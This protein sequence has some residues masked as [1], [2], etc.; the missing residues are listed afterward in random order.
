MRDLGIKKILILVA[1][2][3]TTVIA[4]AAAIRGVVTDKTNQEPLIGAT[5]QVHGTTTGTITDF[6]GQFELAGLRNGT[7]TLIVQYVSY[8]TKAVEISVN[9]IADINIELDPDN[10]TLGEVVVTGTARRNT[11]NAILNQ[12]RTSLVMQTGVSSQQIARTQDKDASEVIRRVPGISIIDEKFVM[13]RGLSQRYN[14]VWINNS[15]VPSSEPDSRAFSFDIIPSSQLDNMVVVKSP[16]PQYPSD[17]SGGFVL[18]NT[19]DVPSNNLFTISLGSNLND[20]THFKDFQYNK[21]S[22]TDFLGFDNGYRSLN[23]GIHTNLTNIPGVDRSVDLL[24]NGF[25]NDWKVRNFKPVADMSLSMNVAQRWVTES[26]RTF[27]LLGSANYS[28]SYK[29]LLN[30]ENALFGAYDDANERSVYLH[31]YKDNQY[32]QNVRIGAMLNLTYVPTSGNSRYEFKNIFNQLARDRYTFRQGTDDQD[33]RTESAEYYYNSRTTYNGQFTGKHTLTDESKVDWSGGYAYASQNMPDRRR[34]LVNNSSET[35][36]MWLE[37]P[38]AINREFTK[39]DEHILSANANYEHNF[40]FGSFTPSIKAGA[41]TEYRTREYNARLFNYAYN[42]SGHTLPSGFRYMNLPNEL[43]QDQYYGAEGLYLLEDVNWINN[44]EGN[45]LLTAGYVGTNLPFGKL[46]IYAGVRF[47]H[48]SMEL[49][50]NT[51]KNEKSPKSHNYTYNDFFP[52]FNAAYKLNPQHQFRLSYGRTTNRPELREVSPAVFYDFDL[53]SNVQGNVD[54]EAAYINNFDIS[55]EFYPSDGELI[56]VSL[57]YKQFRNPIE[58]TYTVAGGT[59][60][61]YSYKNAEGA[62]NYGIELD[63]RKNLDF[64]GLRNFSWN[65]NGSLIKSEVTFAA[66]DLEQDRPMQGQSPYLINT[67]IFYQNPDKGW[68]VAALYNRIGKRIIGVG[69]SVGTGDQ[70]RIPDSYEMPRNSIDLS[71]GK[72]I[73]NKLEVKAAIRDVLAE[74]VSFKQFAETSAGEVEQ[75]TRQYKPGRNFSLN[76][77][78]TF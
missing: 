39:L 43:L 10:Q 54:L 36:E 26:G 34:Y 66:G 25:N 65:F 53:A 52:S 58:W 13:V 74:K 45:N 15:A 46:N 75:V 30:M 62:N 7:Y 32:N 73:G 69:R 14:N 67:G 76:V 4:Q 12:Q 68:N 28:S 71:V 59:G 42:S 72:K 9:G 56:S 21:G 51:R 23:N 77:N 37:N 78:Y 49:I 11:E 5:V 3:M 44:Y 41:Y 17:F 18:V 55:Y 70:V 8:I 19:K 1:L 40:E 2:L 16:S 57:F 22:G 33:N 31:N 20:Q 29:T 48:S 63:I 50:T 64:L 6:D 27:A 24:N 35:G 60:L 61:I 38:N 47:E